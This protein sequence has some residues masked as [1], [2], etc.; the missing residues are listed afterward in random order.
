MQAMPMSLTVMSPL[1]TA[2][3]VVIFFFHKLVFPWRMCGVLIELSCGVTFI[4]ILCNLVAWCGGR[5][6]SVVLGELIGY[7]TFP[8]WLV[9]K[10]PVPSWWDISQWHIIPGCQAHWS[11]FRFK[12][13]SRFCRYIRIQILTMSYMY[14]CSGLYWSLR[15]QASGSL[16]LKVCQ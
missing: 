16:D 3:F 14:T 6:A 5:W 12:N 8:C 15:Y 9:F 1:A 10:G 11:L 2:F 13:V 4:Q 7:S